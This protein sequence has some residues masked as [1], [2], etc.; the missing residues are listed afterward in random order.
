MNPMKKVFI[1]H[2]F[3]GSPNSSWIPWLMAELKK[4]DVYA[5][6][7][8]MPYPESP[9][10]MEWVEEISRHVSTNIGDE[11]YLVGHSLGVAAILN[12]LQQP[13]NKV[14]AG[15]VLVSGRLG[16]S[17]HPIMA[18]FY[19]NIDFKTITS[20]SKAFSIIHGDDDDVVPVSNAHALG[21]ELHTVPT[22]IKNG[23]HLNGSAGFR[24]LPEVVQALEGM[25]K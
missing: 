20:R 11:I 6:A 8:S 21:K 1:I 7:L 25:M 3:G 12:Y 18:E 24:E 9:S 5:C 2:G 4:H 19:E 15:A 22:I 16:K 14:I 23:K 13:F 17:D 10:V